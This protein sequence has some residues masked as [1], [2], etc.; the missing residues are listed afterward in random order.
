MLCSHIELLTSKTESK[1]FRF[2]LALL[3][4][5]YQSYCIKNLQTF[6]ANFTIPNLFKLSF[7]LVECLS[8]SIMSV[9]STKVVSHLSHMFVSIYYLDC[10]FAEQLAISLQLLF[11]TLVAVQGQ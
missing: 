10:P 8:L 11:L 6:L 5:P 2:L 7:L 9:W 3:L 1:S 4:T